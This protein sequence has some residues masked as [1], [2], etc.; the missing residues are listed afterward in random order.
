MSETQAVPEGWERVEVGELPPPYAKF[1]NIGDA[2]VG[3]L[4]R[5]ME[6]PNNFDPKKTD[7][8]WVIATKNAATGAVEERSLPSS[9]TDLKRRLAACKVGD[10]VK[11]SFTDTLD[12]GNKNPMKV[13]DIIKHKGGAKPATQAAPPPAPPAPKTPVATDIPF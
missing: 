1:E 2:I 6:V 10:F 5:T 12:T 8:V 9:L 11:I 7:L 13:F 4:M 3:K